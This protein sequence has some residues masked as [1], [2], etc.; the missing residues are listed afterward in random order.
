MT[1]KLKFKYLFATAAFLLA[2]T[3]LSTFTYADDELPDPQRIE[4]HQME[5][6]TPPQNKPLS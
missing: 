1:M 6:S 2:G 3:S 4:I 5:N